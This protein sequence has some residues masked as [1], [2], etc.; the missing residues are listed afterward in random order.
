MKINFNAKCERL[1]FGKYVWVER[2]RKK[3]FSMVAKSFSWD[4]VFS[5]TYER[6]EKGKI[7]DSVCAVDGARTSSIRSPGEREIFG[8]SFVSVVGKRSRA[9]SEPRSNLPEGYRILGIPRSERVA[10]TRYARQF[11]IRGK[12][13]TCFLQYLKGWTKGLNLF[14]RKL[15]KKFIWTSKWNLLLWMQ[16][17]V[18]KVNGPI[19]EHQSPIWHWKGDKIFIK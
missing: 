8:A 2:E 3:I 18:A 13:A 7:A 16:Q 14:R 19:T 11:W 1:C 5:R 6:Q 10:C 12:S 17:L 4:S 9:Y 15:G